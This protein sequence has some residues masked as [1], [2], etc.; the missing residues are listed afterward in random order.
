MG[1]CNEDI[2][3]CM[4]TDGELRGTAAWA[5]R[6]LR[7]L[8]WVSRHE[9]LA[10]FL[11]RKPL[12]FKNMLFHLFSPDELLQGTLIASFPAVG[13][14]LVLKGRPKRQT[15]IDEYFPMRCD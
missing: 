6:K 4:A 14:T 11:H 10:A 3:F 15:R 5:A 13:C 2:T 8:D 1:T 12:R 7:E 9:C